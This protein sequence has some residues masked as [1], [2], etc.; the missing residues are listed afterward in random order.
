MIF[1]AFN[2]ARLPMMPTLKEGQMYKRGKVN[3]DWKQ[4]TFVLDDKRLCYF[5]GGVS[6]I[7]Q[8][9]MLARAPVQ[10]SLTECWWQSRTFSSMLQKATPAGFINLGDIIEVSP[11]LDDGVFQVSALEDDAE[12]AIQL[13]DTRRRCFT[14]S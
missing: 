11:F 3:P 4:R 6:G 7:R 13:F 14:V 1:I 12:E 2:P 5:K 8:W 10:A 9:L